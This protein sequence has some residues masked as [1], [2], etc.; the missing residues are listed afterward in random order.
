MGRIH[1]LTN[2]ICSLVCE[3]LPSIIN[4]F[5]GHILKLTP[6]SFLPCH[7]SVISLSDQLDMFKKYKRKV[8]EAVGRN[9][10]AII[11]SKSIY[12]VCIGSNDITNTYNTP[13]RRVQYDIPS[14]TDLMASKASN[15]LQVCYQ[16][17]YI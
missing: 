4:A 8:E 14:Y 16:T 7:K 13:F 3:C 17:S 12:I 10:T 5:F 2:Y 1:R 6:V 9:R 15:F 11:V